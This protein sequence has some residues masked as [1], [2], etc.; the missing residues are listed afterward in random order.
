MQRALNCGFVDFNLDD[1]VFLAALEA[2]RDMQQL[3]FIFDELAVTPQR[4]K[5]QKLADD[6]RGDSV[7]PQDDLDS[8]AGRNAQFEMYVS[9]ICQNAGLYPVD[10]SDPD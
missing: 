6:L 10:Y 8:S 2:E 3:G 7:L 4:S 1:P 9:A 5:F